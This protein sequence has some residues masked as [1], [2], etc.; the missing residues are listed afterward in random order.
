MFM[1]VISTKNIE[2]L[3]KS[4]FKLQKTANLATEEIKKL[5]K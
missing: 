3:K 1:F 5:K 2:Y 4:L